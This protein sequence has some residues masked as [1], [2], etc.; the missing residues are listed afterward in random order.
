MVL[1]T[2]GRYAGSRRRSDGG[3]L[4]ISYSLYLSPIMH[5]GAQDQGG[6]TLEVGGAVT[7]GTTAT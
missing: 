7:A 5:T 3:G 1:E 4:L 2:R 6:G